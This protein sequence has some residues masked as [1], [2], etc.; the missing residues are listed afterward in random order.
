MRRSVV[1]LACA[2]FLT[3]AAC[4]SLDNLAGSGSA[5]PID[6]GD[7]A[8]DAT[9]SAPLLDAPAS[10]AGNETGAIDAGD[11]AVVGC[12]GAVGCARYVF[13]TQQAVPGNI[14]GLDAADAICTSE[15]KTNPKLVGRAF[16]AWLSTTPRPVTMRLVHGTDPYRLVNETV[17][18]LS[19]ADLIDG[20]LLSPLDT[21]AAGITLANGETVWTATKPDATSTPA[22]C[23]EW[24]SQT[25]TGVIG[26]PAVTTGAWSMTGNTSCNSN[27]HLYCFEK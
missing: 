15:A 25:G 21:T 23:V 16:V 14:G 22:N 7:S 26:K 11:A 17:V 19:W 20:T 1:W 24:A 12:N 2:P 18:A 10:D 6:G 9:D 4:V 8:S 13:V 27:A 5:T 3:V